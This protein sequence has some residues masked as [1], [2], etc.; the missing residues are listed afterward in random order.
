MTKLSFYTLQHGEVLKELSPHFQDCS[1][2]AH[3]THEAHLRALHYC[4]SPRV[5]SGGYVL[6]KFRDVGRWFVA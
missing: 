6:E 3:T 4:K 1:Y 2:R 5:G